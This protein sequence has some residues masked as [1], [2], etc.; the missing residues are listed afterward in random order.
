[1]RRSL[2][3]TTRRKVIHLDHP[4]FGSPRMALADSGKFWVM[5]FKG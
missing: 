2:F 4:K 3:V 1:M 5:N